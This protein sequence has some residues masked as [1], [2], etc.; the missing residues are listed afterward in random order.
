MSICRKALTMDCNTL[1][2]Q[3]FFDHMHA[4]CSILS[5]SALM[6][7]YRSFLNILHGSLSKYS[8]L[9][10][11][12]LSLFATKWTHRVFFP[13]QDFADSFQLINCLKSVLKKE[14][15]A[16][17]FRLCNWIWFKFNNLISVL[18]KLERDHTWI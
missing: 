10:M 2:Q 16:R 13:C 6:V 7:Y 9:D 4:L 3:T 1:S 15:K 18:I 8:C 11:V 14:D 17:S 5:C 12:S